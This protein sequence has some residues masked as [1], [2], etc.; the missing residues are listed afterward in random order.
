MIGTKQFNSDYSLFNPA[1][2][3]TSLYG[4]IVT[5]NGQ[6]WPFLDVLPRKYRFRFL[7]VGDSRTFHIFFQE[8]NPATQDFKVLKDSP[9]VPISFNMIATDSGLIQNPVETDFFYI[10]IAERYEVV[11]DFA[12]FAGKNIMLRSTPK[13]AADTDYAFTDQLMMFNVAADPVDDPS[14]LPAVLNP[15][16]PFPVINNT[17]ATPNETFTFARK[18][19]EWRING[20]GWDM[21]DQR[22]LSNVPRGTTEIWQLVNGGGGWSH[23][24]HVHLVDMHVIHREGFDR[25]V[26][27]WELLGL[28]DVVWIGPGETAY[29]EAGYQPWDGLYMFHCHNLIHEDVSLPR[30]CPAWIFEHT[31]LITE[32][33]EQHDMLAAF[34]VTKLVDLGYNETSFIDPM[35]ERWQAEPSTPDKFT[36]DAIVAKIKMVANLRPYADIVEVEQALQAYWRGEGDDY[37]EGIPPGDDGYKYVDS[38]ENEDR[39]VNDRVRMRKVQSRK[40]LAGILSHGGGSGGG[41]SCGSKIRRQ[42]ETLSH[43]G[44]CGE[45]GTGEST[46][47]GDDDG[48]TTEPGDDDGTTPEP[49]DDDATTG[50]LKGF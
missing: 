48:N 34:N 19:G 28:K 7:N 38:N 10:S 46:E 8:V 30:G 18:G 37:Q 41:G 49:G 1:D 36:D 47:P 25:D 35:E 45:S 50:M 31:L 27:P 29:V 40:E 26:E 14:E 23:P 4:D 2:E 39:S 6:P 13:V 3:T 32:H 20:V 43:G 16:V 9:A 11:F 15:A 42:T 5:V 44:G 33:R 21:V 17:I 24:I 22:I 12:P